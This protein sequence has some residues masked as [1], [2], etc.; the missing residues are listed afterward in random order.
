MKT[1]LLQRPNLESLIR[2]IK[3]NEDES[4]NMFIWWRI[5]KMRNML[6]FENNREHRIYLIKNA[7]T[8]L[9]LYMEGGNEY[10]LERRRYVMDI[11]K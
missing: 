5:W 8:D 6:I 9:K 10:K 7:I 2:L 11:V 4:T 3:E 1:H